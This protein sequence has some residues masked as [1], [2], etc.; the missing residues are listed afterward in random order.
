MLKDYIIDSRFKIVIEINKINIQNYDNL[1]SFSDNFICIRKEK[2][3]INITGSN[4]TIK[5]LLKD[6][7][8]IIGDIIKIEYLSLND[9]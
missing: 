2:L 1:V 6:E 7:L 5:N 9:K 3:K 4:L 8:L